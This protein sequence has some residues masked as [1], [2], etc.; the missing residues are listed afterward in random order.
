MPAT[1]LSSRSQDI[2]V[3]DKIFKSKEERAEKTLRVFETFSKRSDL[4]TKQALVIKQNPD[5]LILLK[6]RLFLEMEILVLPRLKWSRELFLSTFCP[7][8][9]E[10]M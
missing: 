8:S 6:K 4:F 9:F 7:E 10:H 1:I 3:C 2:P 5:F